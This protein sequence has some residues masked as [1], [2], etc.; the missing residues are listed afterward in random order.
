MVRYVTKSELYPRFGYCTDAGEIFIGDWL[1]KRVQ[2]FV[3]FHEAYHTDKGF[4]FWNE[5]KAN[6]H[7]LFNEPLGGIQT[8]WMSVMNIDRW[9]YYIDRVK[10]GS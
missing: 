4:G 10:N 7:G 1:P 5:V 3:V 2:A 6:I 9:K 8:L